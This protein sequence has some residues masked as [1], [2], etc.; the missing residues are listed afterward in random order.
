MKTIE[1][2]DGFH[3]VKLFQPVC[4][5]YYSIIKNGITIKDGLCLDAAYEMFNLLIKQS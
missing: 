4:G 2:R 5:G 1:E 3:L